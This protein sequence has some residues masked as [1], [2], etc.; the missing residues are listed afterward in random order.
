MSPTSAD[1]RP[2]V[3]SSAVRVRIEHASD[4]VLQR[5]SRLPSNTVVIVLLVLLVA[6]LVVR[7][8]IGAILIG[9][10]ALAHGWGIYLAWPRLTGLERQMRLAVLLLAVALAV[11]CLISAFR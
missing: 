6:G 10:V 11:V 8:W 9:V 5:L 3:H 7:G 2:S 4:P 1:P